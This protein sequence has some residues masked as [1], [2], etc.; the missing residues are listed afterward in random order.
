MLPCLLGRAARGCLRA[1][2]T[3]SLSALSRRAPLF[4]S[5]L[6]R[7]PKPRGKAEPAGAASAFVDDAGD[8]EAEVAASQD[9]KAQMAKHVDWARRELS[10]LRGAAASASASFAVTSWRVLGRRRS[11]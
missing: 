10:K 9:L 6:D 7:A 3:R 11:Q 1:A 5:A 2:P 4:G 8:I